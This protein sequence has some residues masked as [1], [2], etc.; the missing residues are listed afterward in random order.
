MK[1][2]FLAT[3]HHQADFF[4]KKISKIKAQQHPEQL[5]AKW[6]SESVFTISRDYMDQKCDFL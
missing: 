4:Y 1:L 3:V 6:I 5:S 2:A